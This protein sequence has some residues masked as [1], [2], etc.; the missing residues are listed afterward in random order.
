MYFDSDFQFY[1]IILPKNL[2]I[3]KKLPIFAPAK[4]MVR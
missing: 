1:L 2:H 3:S 4:M